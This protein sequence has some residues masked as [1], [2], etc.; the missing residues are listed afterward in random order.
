MRGKSMSLVVCPGSFDPVTNGHL[1]IVTRSAAMFDEVVVAV[2]QNIDK[3]TRFT[4]DERV[5]LFTKA[6]AQHLTMNWQHLRLKW[7][8]QRQFLLMLKLPPCTLKLKI[9]MLLVVS[10]Q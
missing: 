10:E 9:R 7:V 2:L 5:A 8:L 6:A 3:R 4:V 1:D